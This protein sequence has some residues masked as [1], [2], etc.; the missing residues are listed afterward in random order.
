MFVVNLINEYCRGVAF[1]G[2][3]SFVSFILKNKQGN[4]YPLSKEAKARS[5]RTVIHELGHSIGSLRDEYVEAMRMVSQTVRRVLQKRL[6]LAGDQLVIRAVH[7]CRRTYG[8]QKLQ[9]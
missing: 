3:D 5:I 6:L 8:Q 9:S 1:F 7:M 2:G 4:Y